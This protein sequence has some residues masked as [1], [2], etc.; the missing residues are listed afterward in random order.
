MIFSSTWAVHE[1]LRHIFILFE[2]FRFVS[3]SI[4]LVSDYHKKFK[5]DNA[6]SFQFH[7]YE[8]DLSIK[9]SFP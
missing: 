6:F 4:I 7:D 1:T 3:G 8:G 9:A 2:R 5:E